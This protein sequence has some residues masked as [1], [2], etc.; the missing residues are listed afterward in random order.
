MRYNFRYISIRIEKNNIFELFNMLSRA[1]EIL[2]QSYVI[3]SKCQ[4]LYILHS[5]T[6]VAPYGT[7]NGDKFF[8][9]LKTL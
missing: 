7:G 2:N 8:K 6:M 9:I 5:V 4:K 3:L 1:Y